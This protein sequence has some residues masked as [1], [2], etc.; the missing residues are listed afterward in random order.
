MLEGTD[1]GGRGGSLRPRICFR[2]TRSEKTGMNALWWWI[3][4]WRK[5]TAFMDMTLA[6]QGAYRNLLDEA[7]LRGGALPNDERILAKASGDARSWQKH[8]ATVM[9]RFALRDDGWRNETLDA[10][11]HQSER[12][13]VNQS[14]YRKKADNARDNG[15]NNKSD[16]KPDNKHDNKPDSP[17]PISID[18]STPPKGSRGE[19]VVLT[20]DVRHMLTSV[21]RSIGVDGRFNARSFH[22]AVEQ[23]LLALGWTVQRE[24]SVEDRGDGRRGSVDLLVTA[25]VRLAIELDRGQPRQKSIDKLN[26][27]ARDGFAGIA[28][29]RD[30]TSPSWRMVGAVSVWADSPTGAPRVDDASVEHIKK[31]QEVKRLI[32]EEGLTMAE[33]SRRVGYR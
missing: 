15:L 13:R 18:K 8:R 6:E 29:C 12:R 20:M 19:P 16:N 25:P 21:V 31:S 5:S 2:D 27:L 14:N 9:A 1:C 17:D 32:A 4:R 33:A 22:D 24:V 11:L 23:G 26:T 30:G 7:T 28:I 10:V 3:D